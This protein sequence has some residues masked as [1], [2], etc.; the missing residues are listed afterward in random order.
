[1]NSTRHV[2]Q[3]A[4]P[5]HAC[6]MS[7]CT[8]CSIATTSRLSSGT[9]TGAD[10]STVSLAM[11]RVSP[12]PQSPHHTEYEAVAS[13][14]GVLRYAVRGLLRRPGFAAVSIVTLA[15]GIGANAAIFSLIDAVLLRPLPY[16]EP[17]RIVVPWEFNA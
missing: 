12:F 11:S 10:P 15:L 4:L 6:R 5:P 16:P 1:M 3:R 14:L 13:R 2:V 8:S 17:D 9:S 7:T